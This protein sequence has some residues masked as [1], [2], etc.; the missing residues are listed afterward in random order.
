MDLVL[1]TKMEAINIYKAPLRDIQFLLW[2][3]KKVQ[4]TI[5]PHYSKWT[6]EKIDQLLQEAAHFSE[7]VLGSTYK[8]A[9]EQEC[10]Q[11]ERGAVHIPDGYDMLLKEFKEKWAYL[12]H[13]SAEVGLPHIVH[14]LLLEMFLG[15]N[16]SFMP[17]IGFNSLAVELLLTYGTKAQQNLYNERLYSYDWSSC[18]CTTE[19]DAGSDLS[20]LT[21]MAT[22]QDD[23]TYLLEG[24]KRFISA[25]MH[26]LTDNI[27]YFVL[28]RT[29][30]APAGMAG[31]SCFIIN[32]YGLDNKGKA[33]IDNHVRCEEVVS[34][35]GLKGL[36]NTHLSFG[37]NGKCH[38]MLL[39]ETEHIGLTQ[40]IKKMMTPARVSTGI[41]A[42]GMASSAYLNAFNY[43]HQRI[44]GKRFDL[45]MSA[46]APSLAIAEHPDVQR[47]L[48]EMKASTEGCRALIATLGT[49]ESTHKIKTSKAG[50]ELPK[51]SVSNEMAL[52]DIFS[53]VIKAYCSDQSW[54][55]AETAI[56]VYGGNGYLRKYPAEQY[57]R[58]CKILSIWE[59]TNHMQAQFLLR[60]K[61]GMGLSET[62][63]LK[64]LDDS[65]QMAITVFEQQGNWQ[66]ECH[67]LKESYIGFRTA[68][69]HL[70]AKVRTGGILAVPAS[71]NIVLD[72]LAE[73]L[74]AWQLLDAANCAQQQCTLLSKDDND[75]DFYQ[76]KINAA[77][78]FINTTLPVTMSKPK[79]IEYLIENL[80][81]KES[82][83]AVS[84]PELRKMKLSS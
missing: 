51:G 8:I 84:A 26:D 62:K 52:F 21:M 79:T 39:G 61:L 10:W 50:I 7:N 64:V 68:L 40:L 16:P 71:A 20:R 58:D 6:K 76:N 9:D 49:L 75:Y 22:K 35:M 70:G 78:F 57:A 32:R 30:D 14:Y 45:S 66:R 24:E 3:Q 53:P 23:G 34:K 67:L 60:D 65:L 47:M 5:L 83:I 42:L 4:D 33:T 41:Y 54:K 69:Q 15:A 77:L 1:E 37:K 13:P 28:A 43:A 80:P 27:V 31:L 12:F 36:A 11:D 73:I 55:T 72:M 19:A 82:K 18:L 44:Q 38:A 63:Y 17:Y 81:L 46:R 59:G 74:T 48:L 25:G 2:E 29:H 56:Q